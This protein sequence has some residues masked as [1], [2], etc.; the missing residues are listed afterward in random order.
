MNLRG[1]GLSVGILL[2]LP[3]AAFA[4]WGFEGR[5]YGIGHEHPTRPGVETDYP[6]SISLYGPDGSI[7][8]PSLRCSGT[9]R[10]ISGGDP[11]LVRFQEHI[12]SGD[13]VRGGEITL[14]MV[15]GTLS[16]T[17]HGRDDE[18]TFI[19]VVAVLNRN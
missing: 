5:W 13:C 17:W 11:S 1:L 19:T 12:T 8:Y 14:T 7:D 10:R 9:L 15:Q 3:V 6:I 4:Q 16:F 2:A 18:G